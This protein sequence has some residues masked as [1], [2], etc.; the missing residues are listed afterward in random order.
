M[1]KE[2]KR[3]KSFCVLPWI[4]N[5]VNLGGE[6][7]VCCTSE[8]FD[9]HIKDENGNNFLVQEGTTVD[10]VMNSTYMKDLRL[11]MLNGELPDLCARC[12][13]TEDSNGY[14]RRQLENDN[15]SESIDQLIEDTSKDG[16]IPVKIIQADY[17]LGNVCNLQCRM[18]NPRATKKWV[19]DWKTV[20]EGL[21]DDHPKFLI[22]EY[23]NYYWYESDYLIKEFKSK[24]KD[25]TNLHF[26]GGEPFAAKQMI[27]LL[28]HCVDSGQSQL[29]SLSYNTNLTMLP[30]EILELWKQ[31]K[32]VKILASID[33]Y[34]E[35]NSYI[36]PPSKWDVIDRNLKFLDENYKEYNITEI[37]VSTTV[38]VHNI[39]H[40]DQLFNYLSKFKFVI[41]IPNLIVLYYPVYLS[42]F[43][44]PIKLRKL[45]YVKLMTIAENTSDIVPDH[46]KYLHQSIK[47]CAKY[48]LSTDRECPKE[49]F[50]NFVSFTRRFDTIRGLTLKDVNP[51]LDYLVKLNTK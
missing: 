15:L 28:K 33:A 9:N 39:L 7:Q 31:F 17:R 18:C 51:E 2:I 37:I 41:K 44:L 11:K 16:S 38:Q 32:S 43:I 49:V 1:T 29:I 27:E 26:A 22:D 30:P 19:K 50:E 47:H 8:E 6:Y 36:R 3:S 34:G 20:K 46:Y 40:L 42:S 24:S 5:F 4:H 10:K 35:L 48:L 12:I 25:V 14:S 23:K 21:S 13:S 45:A